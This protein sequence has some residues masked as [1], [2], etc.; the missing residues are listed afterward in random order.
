QG[1]GIRG[2]AWLRDESSASYPLGGGSVRAA[3]AVLTL[4]I[5]SSAIVSSARADEDDAAKVR[6]AVH[7]SRSGRDEHALA[8]LAEIGAQSSYRAVALYDAGVIELKL[9]RLARA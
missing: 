3:G 8:L 2:S 1:A 7:E 5:I 6:L 9:G 4:F